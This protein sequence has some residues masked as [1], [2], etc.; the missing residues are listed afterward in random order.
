MQPVILFKVT[1]STE[2]ISYLVLR[3]GDVCLD[4]ENVSTH[5]VNKSSSFSN[6]NEKVIKVSNLVSLKRAVKIVSKVEKL[7]LTI[8]AG[9]IYFTI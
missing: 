6:S 2:Y 5:T 7:G 9:S 4:H 8:F 1:G 3:V